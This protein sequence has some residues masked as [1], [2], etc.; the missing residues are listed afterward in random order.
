MESSQDKAMNKTRSYATLNEL[1]SDIFNVI[2]VTITNEDDTYWV[3]GKFECRSDHDHS[4]T[5]GIGDDYLVDNLPLH[6]D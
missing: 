4:F 6:L 1:F 5:V 2:S 3:E